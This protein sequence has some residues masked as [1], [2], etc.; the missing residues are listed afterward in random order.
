MKKSKISLISFLQALGLTVYCTLVASLIWSLSKSLVTAP[1]I[2]GVIFWLFLLAFSVAI[3]GLIVFGYPGYL[4][5]N[6]KVKDALSILIYTLLYCV[7]IM[8]VIL[9]VLFSLIEI[10]I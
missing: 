7:G 9:V 5:I 10:Q 2:A 8:A 4:V 6:K 3:C 1:G